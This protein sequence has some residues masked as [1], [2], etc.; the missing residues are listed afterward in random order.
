MSLKSHGQLFLRWDTDFLYVDVRGPFN[1]EGVTAGFLQIQQSVG[2]CKRSAWARIDLLDEETLG[3]PEVMRVIGASYKWCLQ[4]GCVAIASV[5]STSIQRQILEQ[6]RQ[7]TGMN[8][9]GFT[10][11]AEAEQWCRD[12]L[13]ERLPPNVV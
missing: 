6:T 11:Q 2:Q 12:Q 3:A 4:H 10:T 5:C 9:A 13:A 7:K 8:L 1:L